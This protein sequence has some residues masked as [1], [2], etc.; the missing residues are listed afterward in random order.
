MIVTALEED[1]SRKEVALDRP[2]VA[3]RRNEGSRRRFLIRL[4]VPDLY[5]WMQ[6]CRRERAVNNL[7]LACGEAPALLRVGSQNH[8][9]LGGK[10]RVNGS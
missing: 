3:R 6:P 4:L 1:R 10:Y 8:R 9:I 2:Y 5:P 7:I